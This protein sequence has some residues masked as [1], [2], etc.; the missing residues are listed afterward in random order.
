MEPDLEAVLGR[1]D[2]VVVEGP[3]AH[4]YLQSQVSQDLAGIAIGEQRWTFVLEPSGKIDSLARITRASDERYEL[5]T[6][7][8]YGADLLGRI[9]RFKIRVRAETSLG[10]PRGAEADEAA[11]IEA[12]WP[13]LGWEIVPGET[14]P[15]GTGLARLAVN[16]TKGCYPGQELV[17]RM[18][19]RQAQAP[20]TLRRLD[21]PAGTRPGDPVLDDGQEVGSVTSVA[22]ERALGWVKRSSDVG[23]PVEF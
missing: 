14:I 2:V 12:G 16:Y 7:H 11:R 19:S 8:G 9:D 23:D 1:R 20:R 13:R 3:D 22:G 6:D 18:D 17:E 15:G 5:D 21:V 4:A 10:E